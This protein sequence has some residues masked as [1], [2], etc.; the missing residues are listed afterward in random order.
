MEFVYWFCGIT[1]GILHFVCEVNKANRVD[2]HPTKRGLE[3]W[4]TQRQVKYS[5]LHLVLVFCSFPLLL[6]PIRSSF[7]VFRWSDADPL[8]KGVGKMR[9]T[10]VADLIGDGIDLLPGGGQ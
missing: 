8:G 9:P 2:P 1:K 6:T 10:G 5:S 3:P 4:E 7:A